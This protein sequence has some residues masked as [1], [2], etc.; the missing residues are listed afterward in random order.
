MMGIIRNN[1]DYKDG[2]P[3][4]EIDILDEKNDYPFKQNKRISSK[5]FIG[6]DE[7]I[8]GMRNTHG[9]GSWMCPDLRDK[10]DQTKVRLSEVLMKN[11]YKK[12]DPIKL[13]YDRTKNELTIEK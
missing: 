6:K 3:A 8:C 13:N 12:N 1:R 7:F 5:L 2:T 9:A 4:F 10:N 11:G